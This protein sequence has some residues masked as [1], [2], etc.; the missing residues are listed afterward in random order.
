MISR[1][2]PL[3]PHEF[4][5]P[6]SALTPM[7]RT[8]CMSVVIQSGVFSSMSAMDT[9]PTVRSAAATITTGRAPTLSERMPARGFTTTAMIVAGMNTIP[10]STALP[11]Q[12]PCTY[13]GTIS[14]IPMNDANRQFCAIKL[15]RKWDDSKM[16]MLMS[17]CSI[18]FW[19]ATKNT[20]HAMPTTAGTHTSGLC[21]PRLA[22]LEKA[23]R[24]PPKPRAEY[25]KDT[26]SKRASCIG[27]SS[28]AIR[29][30]A[31]RIK[32]TTMA[33]NSQKKL[34]HP[35]ESTSA[36][37]M[38]GP[39][40]GANPMAIPAIPIAVPFCPLGKRVIAIDCRTGSVM[41]A[42]TA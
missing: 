31:A 21:T 37:P 35:H 18:R 1:G 3:I 30:N 29:R 6:I 25:R 5:G 41:P 40:F 33:M 2:S 15:M 27:A 16:R 4:K 7:P 32:R 22:A 20:R 34:R 17:G 13:N 39:M 23:S 19:R 14:V 42:P 24:S 26:P 10:A 12:S 38:S 8:V 28:R 36:P 11:P 9:A